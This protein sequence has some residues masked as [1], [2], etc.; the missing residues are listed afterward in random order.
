MIYYRPFE[1]HTHTR[2][3]DG[4]FLTD[5]LIRACAAYGYEGMALTDHNAVTANN[6]V[7]PALLAETGIQ[8]IPGIEWTTFYGHL[9]VLGC[10]RYVDWRFVTPDTID[11]ALAEIQ[12]A[13]GVAGIAHPC[14]V[15]APLMC[16]C[17][18]EFR[19]TRWDL[20]DYIE[21]WSEDQPHLRSKNM[22]ALPW[23]DKLLQQGHRLA[24]SAGRDW[25]AA[26]P[27][28]AHPPLLTATY[29]GVEEGDCT[30]ENALAALRAGRTYITLGP[31]LEVALLCAGKTYG[32]GDTMPAGDAEL[33]VTVG[34]DARRALWQDW[35][36]TPTQVRVVENG[37]A[38]AEA[39]CTG[40]AVHVPLSG[41]RGWVR[42]E[43][44]GTYR[45]SEGMQRLAITSPFY[46]S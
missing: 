26:D 40:G 37:A 23:Y 1:L 19:V 20:V 6:D 28:P 17:H 31:T 15:G 27:D 29:L 10:A 38:V 13:G 30:P 5:E 18:W 42:A 46:F 14:E 7:T 12:E 43:L 25:H 24:V 9:L 2:H 35:E 8:V 16:G 21:L 41:A 39:D 4:R 32:L 34:T 22:L 3:S 45:G 44:L 11:A 36:I 33:T